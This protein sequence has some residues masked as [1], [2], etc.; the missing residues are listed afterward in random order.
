MLTNE[1]IVVGRLSDTNTILKGA[2]KNFHAAQVGVEAGKGIKA[3]SI[4]SWNGRAAWSFLRLQFGRSIDDEIKAHFAEIE[5]REKRRLRRDERWT[6]FMKYFEQKTASISTPRRI[7]FIMCGDSVIAVAS[8]HHLL[9]PPAEVYAMGEQIVTQAFPKLQVSSISEL[10]GVQYLVEEKAGIQVGLQLYGGSIDTREA[11]T[12]SS[13]LRVQQCFN[14]LSW[15]GIGWFG[16]FTGRGSRDFERL[17]RLKVKADLEPRLRQSITDAL[18]KTKL[19][20]ERVKLARKTPV[21]RT[22]AEIILSAFGLSYSLGAKTIDQI[23]DLLPKEGSTQ[24][25][26]SMASSYVAAHGNFKETPKGQQRSVEQKLSTVAGATLLIDDIKDA[27]EKS[28]EWL[29]AH[30][31]RGQVGSLQGLMKRLGIKGKT[32]YE[33]LGEERRERDKRE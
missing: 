16:N 13:W 7:Q 28:V 20:D 32:S 15:L 33:T 17:L 3:Y 11:I 1:E 12:V 5:K 18:E 9:L 31:T 25:G 14:P 30:V 21:R 24:W 8:L 26:M 22:D 29:K 19:L 27:K 2:R 23:L 6:E 4:A 10:R